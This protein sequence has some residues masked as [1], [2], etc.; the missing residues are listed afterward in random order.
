MD[1][2]S[3]E[4]L[5]KSAHRRIRKLLARAYL[6]ET[7]LVEA[8]EV[9][10]GVLQD[11][12]DD[13]EVLIVLG[14]L[15]RIAGSP[16]TAKR[17]YQTVIAAHP[18]HSI[19]RQQFSLIEPIP[20]S[21][22]EEAFPLSPEA[23]GRLADRLQCCISGCLAEEIR[24]AANMLDSSLA[25]ARISD[26]ADLAGDKIH[27]LMPALVAL[28]I[29]QARAAGHADLAEALQSL[30]INLVR[31]VDERWKDELLRQEPISDSA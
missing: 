5:S 12:P 11:D 1:S 13:L 24:S 8:L 15:Y 19:I 7:R 14:N 28:N 23:V 26:P 22:F 31:Q 2:S 25:D 9:Y 17:L 21:E 27:Q 10:L 20:A 4:F 16:G 29:R 30:Q 18:D 6:N 3:Y